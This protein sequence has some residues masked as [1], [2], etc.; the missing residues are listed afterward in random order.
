VEFLI[1]GYSIG[2]PKYHSTITYH[3]RIW[4]HCVAAVVVVLFL[5]EQDHLPLRDCNGGKKGKH[6]G[7]GQVI[8]L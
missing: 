2:A 1:V 5:Q 8:G 7:H 3:F 6:V 4:K